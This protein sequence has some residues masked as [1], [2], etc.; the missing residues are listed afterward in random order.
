MY[1]TTANACNEPNSETPLSAV[2]IAN[3]NTRVANVGNE[4]RFV[5]SPRTVSGISIVRGLVGLLFWI[6][7]VVVYCCKGSWEGSFPERL[8]T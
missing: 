2:A 4:F 5:G 1:V 8:V 3:Q 7:Q 6:W